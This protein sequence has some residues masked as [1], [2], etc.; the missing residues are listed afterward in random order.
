MDVLEWQ[1][2]IEMLENMDSDESLQFAAW[3]EREAGL[4]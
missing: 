2:L 4:L 1:V 3:I